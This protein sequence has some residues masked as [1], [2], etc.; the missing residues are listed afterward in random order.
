MFLTATII[1][2]QTHPSLVGYLMLFCLAL[3]FSNTDIY[4]YIYICTLVPQWVQ[5]RALPVFKVPSLVYRSFMYGMRAMTFWLTTYFTPLLVF[6]D[7]FCR[8]KVGI[9]RK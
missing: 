3:A 2:K 5:V 8:M 9:T 4:I 7:I 6:I 1:S